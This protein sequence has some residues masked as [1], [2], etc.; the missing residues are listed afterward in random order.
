MGKIIGSEWPLSSYGVRMATARRVQD[1][2]DRL[3]RQ[4]DKVARNQT[5]E[6]LRSDLFSQA[7]GK[8]LELGV[9]TGAT[10]RHYP[11]TLSSLTALDV[12]S[13]MLH[14]AQIAALALPFP[15][16]LMQR[17]FQTLPFDDQTFDTVVSSLAFCGI[18]DPAHLFSEVRRVLRPGGHLLALEHVRP[19]NGLLGA[20]S[21]LID[22]VF[23]RVVGC[24][25]NRRMPERLQA[26]G[27]EVHLQDRR[28]AGIVISLIAV[29][30]GL[31]SAGP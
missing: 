29:P 15:V 11:P 17:D 23:D 1:I 3:A 25:P 9:G 24:H 19:P 28:L 26:A 6:R 7:H 4:Y 18:P 31:D 10:F 20:T 21:D 30:A 13:T 2:Y 5:L 8:V 22:P 12:S 14:G 27:F 16:R